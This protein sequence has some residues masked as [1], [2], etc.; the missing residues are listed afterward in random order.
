M[1]ENLTDNYQLRQITE[2]N[3]HDQVLLSEQSEEEL[4]KRTYTIKSTGESKKEERTEF[5]IT[6]GEPSLSEIDENQPFSHRSEKYMQMAKP[7]VI[8]QDKSSDIV[9]RMLRNEISVSEAKMQGVETFK[10]SFT[11]Q[12]C[13]VGKQIE[14]EGSKEKEKIA[15]SF[16]ER[17]SYKESIRNIRIA[18]E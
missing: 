10:R 2:T 6:S 12:K 5:E 18:E 14:R 7:K 11:N 1:E 4:V 16:A 17:M 15:S 8:V 13:V 9:K 3:Q